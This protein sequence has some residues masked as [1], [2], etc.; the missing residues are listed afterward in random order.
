MRLNWHVAQEG[1]LVLALFGAL[2]ILL[3]FIYLPLG[4]LALG[5]MIW[6]THILRVPARRAPVDPK[7]IVAPADGRI[8]DVAVEALPTDPDDERTRI[9][10]VTGITDAQLQIC[11]VDA[12]VT[13]NFAIPGLFLPVDDMAA[14]RADG[15]RREI[16]LAVEGGATILIVQYGSRTARQLVCMHAEGK[17]LRRGTPLGMARIAGA[18]DVYLPASVKSQAAIGQRAIAGETVL[19]RLSRQTKAATKL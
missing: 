12:R 11:P 13:D 4:T 1:W 10:I 15:E 14:V 18:L 9:T 6:L 3:S 7:D 19:G 2:T 8:V 5:L 17:Y 16:T